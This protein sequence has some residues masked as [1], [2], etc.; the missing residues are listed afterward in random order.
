MTGRYYIEPADFMPG[1]MALGRGLESRAQKQ[2]EIAKEKKAADLRQKAVQVIR[3]GNP[4]L[5]S[6]L[7][8]FSP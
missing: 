8:P 2:L 3:S 6:N 4:E 7:L 5:V 1:I